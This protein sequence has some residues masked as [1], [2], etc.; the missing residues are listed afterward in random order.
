VVIGDAA[1]RAA[2][3]VGLVDV[4]VV[5]RDVHVAP[6]RREHMIVVEGGHAGELDLLQSGAA[7]A[8]QPP[9][10]PSPLRINQRPSW[11]QFGASMIIS[12]VRN[13]S[14]RGSPVVEAIMTCAIWPGSSFRSSTA[15]SIPSVA[16]KGAHAHSLHE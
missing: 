1:H 13:T 14:T 2:V 16:Y 11:V 3:Q 8:R 15:M 4:P 10:L 5:C 6:V 7:V 9:Q 12:S